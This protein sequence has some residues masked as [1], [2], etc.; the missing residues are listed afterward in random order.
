VFL[1]QIYAY[2]P[3]FAIPFCILFRLFLFIRVVL[4]RLCLVPFIYRPGFLALQRAAQDAGTTALRFQPVILD[5][6]VRAF[7]HL[8]KVGFE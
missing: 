1:Q 8:V 3:I 5:A 6:V 4:N 7:S 2:W